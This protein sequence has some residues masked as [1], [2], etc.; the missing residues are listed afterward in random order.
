MNSGTSYDS[1]GKLSDPVGPV[2][3]GSERTNCT[4]TTQLS[5]AVGTGRSIEPT[6]PYTIVANM[7]N[8]LSQRIMN[9]IS[10]DELERRLRLWEER[11]AA[12]YSLPT[13]LDAHKTVRLRKSGVV[14]PISS[15]NGVQDLIHD[16]SGSLLP[17]STDISAVD[18][19]LGR[20]KTSDLKHSLLAQAR[21]LEH[22]KKLDIC[23][24]LLDHL[25]SH[26]NYPAFEA[27]LLKLLGRQPN[28]HQ[29]S[30]LYYL[31]RCAVRHLLT[32]HFH[33][34]DSL[35][36][37]V[38]DLTMTGKSALDS[39]P[40]TGSSVTVDVIESARLTALTE[41]GVCRAS[42]ERIKDFT[43]TFFLRWYADWVYKRGG[44]V[45]DFSI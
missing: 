20:I 38:A 29:I 5:D 21:R 39:Q 43:V 2:A 22:R 37:T 16:R 25:V 30:V 15:S 4:H 35:N 44:W 14:E 24:D 13:V 27:D 7:I 40:L 3:V 8:A 18:S 32:A 11:A 1:L 19:G 42:V 10:E 12:V 36:Q 17:G 41:M 28:W 45:G 33:K 9:Q 6:V 34:L 26:T 23:T 31:S